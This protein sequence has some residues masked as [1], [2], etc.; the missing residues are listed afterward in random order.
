[1]NL[2]EAHGLNEQW[3]STMGGTFSTGTT[4]ATGRQPDSVTIADLNRDGKDDLVLANFLDDSVWV[5]LGDS[6][7][8][9]SVAGDIHDR[10]P[11]GFGHGT[12]AE[13]AAMNR[14]EQAATES[15]ASA[16]A[17]RKS[18]HAPAKPVLLSTWSSHL[19]TGKPVGHW[20]VEAP[21]Q[22]GLATGVAAADVDLRGQARQPRSP[23]QQPDP[24][25]EALANNPMEENVMTRRPFNHILSPADRI[26]VGKWAR[27]VAAFYASIALLALIGVAVAH[28]RGEGAQNQF[29]ICGH[30]N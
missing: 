13:R 11:A 25:L 20:I 24:K 27:G 12:F 19:R 18:K 4:Y 5:R 6:D 2:R 3:S 10:Q 14:P 1:L 30:C 22:R 8:H 15:V 17:T 26:T 29:V 7:G 28:H 9:L 16:I 23:Q 21:P